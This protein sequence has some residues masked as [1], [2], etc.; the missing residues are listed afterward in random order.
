[1][2]R[3]ALSLVD[4]VLII[5]GMREIEHKSYRSVVE[6]ITHCDAVIRAKMYLLFWF[7]ALGEAL[8]KLLV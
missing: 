4:V 1:M 5:A 2:L 7:G 8:T 3:L 6:K